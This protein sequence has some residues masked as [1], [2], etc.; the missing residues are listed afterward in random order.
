[1]DGVNL[2]C[3]ASGP[4]RFKGW[5][6]AD[7]VGALSRCPGLAWC[8]HSP[9]AAACDAAKAPATFSGGLP[10]IDWSHITRR[11][12]EV[13]HYSSLSQPV[14]SECLVPDMEVQK[15]RSPAKV[16]KMV[17]WCVHQSSQGFGAEARPS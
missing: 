7:N 14:N 5:S 3:K 17:V 12:L 13:M 6:T 9:P 4:E 16:G 8:A 10:L 1:M 15:P 2:M 11:R